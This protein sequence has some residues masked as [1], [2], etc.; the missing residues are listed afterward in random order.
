[1]KFT[2]TIAFPPRPKPGTSWWTRPDVQASREAF[3]AWVK[4]EQDRIVGHQQFGG[5]KKTHDKSFPK[6]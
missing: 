3:N 4:A 6:K 2:D 1:M 5:A